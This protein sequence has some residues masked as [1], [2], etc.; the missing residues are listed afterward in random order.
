[1]VDLDLVSYSYVIL[2]ENAILDLE[3]N[4]YLINVVVIMVNIYFIYL[5]DYYLLVFVE[6]RL[7]H[8]IEI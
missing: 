6:I 3:E 8:I 1:M 4:Y 7:L 2:V 5:V